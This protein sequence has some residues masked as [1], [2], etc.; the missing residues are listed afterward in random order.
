MRDRLGAVPLQLQVPIGEGSLFSGVVDI[1]ATRVIEWEDED[2]DV[3]VEVR[4]PPV[5][6]HLAPLS[7]PF[8]RR[9]EAFGA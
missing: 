1:V 4:W 6:R 9:M 7:P 2:G 8:L 5:P 3:V